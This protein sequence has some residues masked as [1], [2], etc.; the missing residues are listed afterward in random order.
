[1]SDQSTTTSDTLEKRVAELEDHVKEIGN[2]LYEIIQEL[3]GQGQA[4]AIAEP[5]CPPIC[6]R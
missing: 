5:V 1:M 4:L 2:V 6:Q 3:R